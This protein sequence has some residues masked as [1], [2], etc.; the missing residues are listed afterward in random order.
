MIAKFSRMGSLP[1]FL[2]HGASRARAP[3]LFQMLTQSQTYYHPI[4]ILDTLPQT[5]RRIVR[6]RQ[7][8]CNHLMSF[9]RVIDVSDVSRLSSHSTH[10][11]LT[12]AS[13]YC[14]AARQYVQTVARFIVSIIT[15]AHFSERPT[16]NQPKE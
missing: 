12:L 1:H 3:L 10:L 5:Q 2:T 6:T 11:L 15:S 16:Y 7:R 14:V 13:Q 8:F 9:K 4:S